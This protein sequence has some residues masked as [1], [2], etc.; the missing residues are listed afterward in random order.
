MLAE[1]VKVCKKEVCRVMEAIETSGRSQFMD[2]P[3]EGKVRES[4][5]WGISLGSQLPAAEAVD[6]E[7]Q[8]VYQLALAN[9]YNPNG[10]LQLGENLYG[11]SASSGEPILGRPGQEIST[12]V[13]TGALELSNVDLA[14]EF[15]D[16]IVTQRGY[17]A[18]ARVVTTSDELLQEIVQLKR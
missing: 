5:F 7:Q 9:V 4:P 6:G 11:L 1:A 15:T 13:V 18:S 16:M 14:Q 2:P 8:E 12:S 17:Q 10:L 3:P